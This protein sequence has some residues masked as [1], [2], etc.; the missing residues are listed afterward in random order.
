MYAHLSAAIQTEGGWVVPSPKVLLPGV[1]QIISP[2][3]ELLD[4]SV[5]ELLD[6]AMSK[7]LETAQ[8]FSEG[9]KAV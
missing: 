5:S 7:L 6:Q 9:V 4:N 2:E 8:R 1:E 3:G